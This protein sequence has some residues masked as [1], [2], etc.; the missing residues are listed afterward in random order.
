MV[1]K[2]FRDILP[3]AVGLAYLLYIGVTILSDRLGR[4]GFVI[5]SYS[6]HYTKL[7]DPL[8]MPFNA[9]FEALLRDKRTAPR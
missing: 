4:F 9:Q 6:I 8:K 7:Y 1:S 3:R 2:N 5:T